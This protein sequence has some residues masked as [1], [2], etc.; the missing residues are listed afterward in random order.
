MLN[1]LIFGNILMIASFIFKFNFLPPQ[2]PLFYNRPLGESQLADTWMIFL[3][4]FI[5]N[6]L[7]IVNNY[8]E[9]KIFLK[10]Y[11]IKKVFKYLNFFLIITFT[12]IFIKIIFLIS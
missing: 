5:L 9:N 7:Y 2:I 6:I 3:I 11:L 12:L 10:N 4:P 1:F 8:L